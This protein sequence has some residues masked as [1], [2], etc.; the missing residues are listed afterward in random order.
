LGWLAWSLWDGDGW[1]K[2]SLEEISLSGLLV[3]KGL[4][5]GILQGVIGGD[6]RFV[7]SFKSLVSVIL[8]LDSHE[9]HSGVGGEGSW[10]SNCGTSRWEPLNH[11]WG[12]SI[13]I[14]YWVVVGQ[15]CKV[16]SSI[17]SVCGYANNVILV[18]W[19]WPLSTSSNI[20][21]SSHIVWCSITSSNEIS[22]CRESAIFPFSPL[23]LPGCDMCSSNLEL[24]CSLIN[25]NGYL[26]GAL[27]F[28]GK[29]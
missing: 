19:V 14:H 20:G 28:G 8:I 9:V 22:G 2:G 16:S 29:S 12:S 15:S 27:I 4:V 21:S 17:S 6:T 13:T 25:S 18:N 23:E 7:G 11:S 3:S 10:R 5:V 26:K 24:W 1:L